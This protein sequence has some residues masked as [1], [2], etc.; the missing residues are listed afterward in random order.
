MPADQDRDVALSLRAEE[1]DIA[2]AAVLGESRHHPAV[3]ALGALSE[4][5][6]QAPSLVA[7]GTVL[8]FGLA[9]SR[10]RLAEAGTRMLGSILVAIA[11][12]SAVKAL[13]SRTRPHAVLD[14][15]E[16]QFEA[17]GEEGPA[18]HSFPSGHTAGGVAAA[19]GL[20]RTYPGLA[21]PSY[22]AAAAI[23]L[24]QLPRAKHYP[25]D[26]AAGAVVGLASEAIVAAAFTAIRNRAAAEPSRHPSRQVSE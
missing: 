13:V 18:E 20:V 14:G 21:M 15:E 17:R 4:I 12:K 16:Y 19:R 3:R 25:A 2:V 26:L 1:A 11:I 6:D 10:P 5:A 8:A 9:T 22:G 23:A 7:C 24:V